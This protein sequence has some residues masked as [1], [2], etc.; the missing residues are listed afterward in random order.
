MA[1]KGRERTVVTRIRRNLEEYVRTCIKRKLSDRIHGPPTYCDPANLVP[2]ERDGKIEYASR[3]HPGG[4]T[5][6]PVPR[7]GEPGLRQLIDEFA[8]RDL[9]E[10]A[11]LLAAMAILDAPGDTVGIPQIDNWK[12]FQ[13]DEAQQMWEEYRSLAKSNDQRDW[14]KANDLEKRLQG[15]TRLQANS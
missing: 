7:V 11:L 8:V 4:P 14:I 9:V 13:G 12:G 5:E 6:V 1:Q 2:V 3:Q 15:L 10:E